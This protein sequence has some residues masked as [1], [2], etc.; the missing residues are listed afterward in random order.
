MN[1]NDPKREVS[2]ME[3]ETEMVISIEGNKAHVFI[4][5]TPKAQFTIIFNSSTIGNR[6]GLRMMFPNARIQTK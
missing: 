4:G 3:V 2:A 1:T 6:A 5:D